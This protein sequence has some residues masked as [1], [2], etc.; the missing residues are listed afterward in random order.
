MDVVQTN[1]DILDHMEPDCTASMQK[2]LKKGGRSEID[3]LI[4]EAVRMGRRL[5]VPMPNYEEIAAKF[6]YRGE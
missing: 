4:F 5:G 6:G 3:G 1:L 2:D